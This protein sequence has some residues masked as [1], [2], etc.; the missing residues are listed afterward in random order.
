MYFSTWCAKHHTPTH[1][2]LPNR[3][4][5]A[6]SKKESVF[7]LPPPLPSGRGHYC[8]KNSHA[9]RARFTQLPR[10]G[11]G[12]PQSSGQM[13]GGTIAT[14]LT[15]C[16]RESHYPPGYFAGPAVAVRQCSAA[17]FSAL[18]EIHQNA[19][20]RLTR[21]ICQN[22]SECKLVRSCSRQRPTR[23]ISGGGSIRHYRG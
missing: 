13:R 2:E 9:L 18:R 3:I 19:E 20:S 16:T 7:D 17:T 8:A 21:K 5:S 1:G 11:E 15:S 22:P 6:A 12:E 23:P 4:L 10:E 14:T